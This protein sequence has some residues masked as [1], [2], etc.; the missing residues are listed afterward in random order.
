VYL[1]KDKHGN[2]FLEKDKH[3]RDTTNMA[4][5]EQHAATTLSPLD[6]T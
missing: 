4:N 3:R 1:E 2:I 5:I 6:L